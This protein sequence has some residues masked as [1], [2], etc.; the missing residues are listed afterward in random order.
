VEPEVALL[1]GIIFLPFAGG[2]LCMVLPKWSAAIAL[3]TPFPTAF[4]AF[5]VLYSGNTYYF[6]LL[7]SFG[8]HLLLDP[9]AA[10]FLLTNT[11]VSLAVV[12][13]CHLKPTSAF[14]FTLLVLLHGSV[15]GAFISSDLFTTYVV[16]ELSTII[17]FALICYPM[18][19]RSLWNGLRYLMFSNIGMLFYLIGALIVY[20]STLSFALP[21]VAN[22]PAIASTLL[23]I[24]L[25]IK[26]GVFIPGLWLPFTH[27][28][29]ATPVS[30]ILS[31]VVVNIGLFPLLKLAM[32]SEPLGLLIRSLGI[33]SAFLGLLFACFENDL[34]RLL[35]FSTVSQVGF[36]LAAPYVGAFY[37]LCHGITKAALFL[38]CGNLPTRKL[39]DL[40]QSGVSRSC[41]VILLMG[42]LSLVGMPLFGTFSAKTMMVK[43][44]YPWQQPL[45]LAASIGTA[46]YAA[47]FSFFKPRRD[48]KTATNLLIPS[49]MLI[50]C[51]LVIG[52]MTDPFSPTL[53]QKSLLIANIGWIVG[54]FMLRYVSVSLP[55]HLERFQDLL[56]FTGVVLLTMILVIGA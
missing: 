13:Y 5:Q 26:G 8:V 43:T 27:A 46:I 19:S 16:I 39:Q 4:V 30:A 21:Q 15:N 17:A 1:L 52:L 28:Q 33:C 38:C 3:L 20:Q 44:L 40:R 45:I 7:D 31:G 14:V 24:G 12:I 36:I 37:A 41:W 10:W 29:A 56:G 48:N 47:K 18:N 54:L 25:M 6:N 51:A 42:G 23:I 32:L 22:S 9:F 2:L 11:L 53:W 34:K 55:V 35:A 50:S 49:Y